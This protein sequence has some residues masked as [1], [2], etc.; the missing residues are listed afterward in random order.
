MADQ[1]PTSGWY[2]RPALWPYLGP[3]ARRGEPSDI[4]YRSLFEGP[5]SAGPAGSGILGKLRPFDLA[6]DASNSG[7][8]ASAKPAKQTGGI[9]GNLY[10]APDEVSPSE[11]LPDY[12]QPGVQL[13]G[14]VIPRNLRPWESGQAGIGFGGGSL[15]SGRRF[16]LPGPAVLGPLGPVAPSAPTVPA[17]AK[18]T[19]GR[20]RLGPNLPSY[21]LPGTAGQLNQGLWDFLAQL[22][23]SITSGFGGGGD[24][25]DECRREWAEAREECAKAFASG[26]RGVYGSEAYKKPGA[27]AWTVH[28]CARGR[29]SQRCG[30][31]RVE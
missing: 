31:N 13:A 24:N 16:G 27:G 3:Q 23:R 26:W 30:G 1:L 29:V 15:G 21:A 5:D 17:D 8:F 11:A 9:L 14:D 19:S 18:D 28:D 6:F 12:W 7:L 10:R 2:T 20:E 22:R 25:D 4:W